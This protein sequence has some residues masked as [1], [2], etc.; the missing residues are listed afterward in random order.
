VDVETVSSEVAILSRV[1]RPRAGT[2]S[3]AAAR[4]WLQLDF[5]EEDRAK[6]RGLVQKAQ[7]GELT[8]REEEELDGYRRAGRVIDMMHSKATLSLKKRSSGAIR[9]TSS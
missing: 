6:M 4:A 9:V 1:L 2:L 8:Q 7:Q 5:A 3:V